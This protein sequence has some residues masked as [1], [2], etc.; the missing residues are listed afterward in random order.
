[1][2]HSQD[3]LKNKGKIDLPIVDLQSSDFSTTTGEFHWEIEMLPQQASLNT[4]VRQMH[5]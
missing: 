4:F 5:H 2:N 1:M 3:E